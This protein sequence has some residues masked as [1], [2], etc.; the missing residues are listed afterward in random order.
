M[1]RHS[2]DILRLFRDRGIQYSAQNSRGFVQLHCPKCGGDRLGFNSESSSFYCWLC[3]KMPFS[4]TVAQL[5]NTTEIEAW[6]ILEKYRGSISYCKKEEK[7]RGGAQELKY[8]KYIGLMAA[9]HRNYLKKRGLDPD[10]V[11]SEFGQVYGMPPHAPFLANTI[12]APLYYEEEAVSW[13]AR[14]I[15]STCPKARRYCT[16]RPEDEII[17]HKELVYGMDSVPGDM[18][19]AVEGLFDVWKCGPGAIHTFGTSWLDKQAALLARKF[20]KGYVMYDA[21]GSADPNGIAQRAGRALAAALAGLGL[22]MAV[23]DPQDAKDPGDWPLDKA[24]GF[25]RELGF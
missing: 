11:V 16:C 13:Q 22:E 5:L 8:P 25:M 3:R 20:R 9:S 2:H 7:K 24:R 4:R 15:V 18:F 21:Q 14:S 6:K 10:Q 1:V 17:W 19:V 23:V 12:I